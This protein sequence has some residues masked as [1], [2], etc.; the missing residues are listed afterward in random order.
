MKAHQQVIK[1]IQRQI[2]AA[3]TEMVLQ[4]THSCCSRSFDYKRGRRQIDISALT[5]ILEINREEKYILLESGV[6]MEQAV[7]ALRP[8]HLS[9][10]VVPE[11][12]HM[13]IGGAIQGLGGESASFMRGFLDDSVLE[14]GVILADGSCVTVQASGCYADLFVA[15]PGSQGS[16]AIITSIKLRLIEAAQ[17]VR[18]VYEQ[19]HSI[20]KVQEI[21]YSAIKANS[22]FD[23]IEC[24][25]LGCNDFRI[26]RGYK[27]NRIGL[28]NWLTNRCTFAFSWQSGYYHR[29]IQDSAQPGNESYLTYEDYLFRWDKGAFW[30][31]A[32]LLDLIQ[33]E[34][35]K[36]MRRL[37][38]GK[39]LSSKMLFTILHRFPLAGREQAFILQDYLMPGHAMSHFFHYL[40]K[41]LMLY[42]LWLIPIRPLNAKKPF[43]LSSLEDDMFV[44]FGMWGMQKKAASVKLN[45]EI[46]LFAQRY[47]GK[48]WLWCQSYLQE[49]E[50][51]RSYD[52][53]LYNALRVKYKA[54]NKLVDMYTKVSEFYR[55]YHE[56]PI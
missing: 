23:F 17:Y 10:S 1:H 14:Y 51:W 3:Q 21:F 33:P 46:E 31:G 32:H 16:L 29:F 37:A 11:F 55:A 43:S 27:T 26:A 18:V 13:T 22:G 45:R 39:M 9:L 41:N 52:G 12:R 34:K 7:K 49:D 54:E 44:E 5:H 38:L 6:T 24:I 48:K 28:K 36:L 42:P 25:A 50:F 20:E 40:A 56:Q 53:N 47:N 30:M 15:I 4:R 35:S 8:Y 19:A 2:K